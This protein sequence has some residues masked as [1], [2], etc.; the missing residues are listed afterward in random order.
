MGQEEHSIRH[1]VPPLLAYF[2]HTEPE[3]GASDSTMR[4]LTDSQSERCL[5]VIR[6]SESVGDHERYRV[7]A[8]LIGFT[9]TY[10]GN[11]ISG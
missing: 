3:A 2:R 9:T 10:K 4:R 5:N 7:N 1:P 11:N 8:K 6:T